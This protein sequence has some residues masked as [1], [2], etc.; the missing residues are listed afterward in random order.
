MIEWETYSNKND[1][2]RKPIKIKMIKWET[3]LIKLIKWE[4][5]LNK[6][7]LNKKNK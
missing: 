4:N 3:Y 2:M 1:W 6:N 7:D 5:Y